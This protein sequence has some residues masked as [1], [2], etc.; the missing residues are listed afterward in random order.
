M[1]GDRLG[2]LVCEAGTDLV[3]WRQIIYRMFFHINEVDYQSSMNVIVKSLVWV[4]GRVWN[5]FV[6][7]ASDLWA[8]IYFFEA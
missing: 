8:A 7:I 3:K 4:G 5:I 1:S 2:P 6:I